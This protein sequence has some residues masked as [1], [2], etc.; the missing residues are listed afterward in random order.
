VKFKKN[1]GYFKFSYKFRKFWVGLS[2]GNFSADGQ[3][4]CETR[5]YHY[6]GNGFDNCSV[7]GETHTFQWPDGAIKPTWNDEEDVVGCG[8]LL[9][10]NNKLS[11]FFTGNGILM[12]QFVFW[13]FVT[14]F[15]E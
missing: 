14:C 10:P 15:V 3:F 7:S 11:I 13:E 9:S 1:R 4:I 12:G 8:L 5:N 6:Y 2:N